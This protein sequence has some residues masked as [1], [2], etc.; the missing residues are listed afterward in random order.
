M[1]IGVNFAL[2]GLMPAIEDRLALGGPMILP[3]GGPTG[4]GGAFAQGQALGLIAGTAVQSQ[5]QTVTITTNGASG[6]TFYPVFYGD[7][8]YSGLTVVGGVTANSSA[9]FPTAAQLQAALFNAIPVWNNNLAVTGSVG[10]PYTITWNNLAANKRIGGLLQ[11]LVSS[12]TGGPP[13]AAVTISQFGWAGSLQAD[14][15]SQASNNRV[16]GFLQNFTLLD[17]V[18]GHNY[19]LAGDVGQA[20]GGEPC[21]RKG[22][23]YYDPVNLP[24][25]S[26]VGIDAN[27]LTLGKLII[28]QGAS[29]I[30]APGLIVELL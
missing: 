21:W 7:Q 16:D 24:E 17:P 5:I 25:K 9:T 30:G 15:Y 11:F 27:A 3:A 14:V 23:F 12:S 13:T 22:L 1:P 10:G 4:V 8:V 2:Q 29:G 19:D 20:M 6:A 18:G 28:Y 26:V